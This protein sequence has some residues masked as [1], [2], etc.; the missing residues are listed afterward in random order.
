MPRPKYLFSGSLRGDQLE[1]QIPHSLPIALNRAVQT[2]AARAFAQG[3]LFS[4]KIINGLPTWIADDLGA[5]QSALEEC[6]AK[7]LEK[8]RARE[9]YV[10]CSLTRLP[11]ERIELDFTSTDLPGFKLSSDAKPFF[12]YALTPYSERETF[13][14]LLPLDNDAE[15]KLVDEVLSGYCVLIVDDSE[16]AL[17]YESRLVEKFGGRAVCARTG[18]EAI[19]KALNDHFDIVLMDIK[20]PNVDGNL[21]M[22]TLVDKRYRMPVVALSAFTSNQE[23]KHS[24]SHGFADYLSKPIVPEQ[25]I[26]TIARLTN[27]SLPIVHSTGAARF[28]SALL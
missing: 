8:S 22:K 7:Q 4:F 27:R 3:K 14:S 9:T 21:A 26:R 1:N 12:T 5:F 28:T 6:L 13:K 15:L 11:D 20:M 19:E 25:L 24:L 18:T 10:I 2:H 17:A 23:R 16:E